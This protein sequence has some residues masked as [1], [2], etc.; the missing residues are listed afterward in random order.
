MAQKYYNVAQTAEIL[1][2]SEDAVKQMQ[3]NR[4]LHG[5]RDG[6]DW[7]FKVE[8]IDRMANEG[9]E[10]PSESDQADV[11]LSEVELGESD[12]GA[13]GTVIGMETGNKS[14]A[15]SDLRIADDDFQ[16][17]DSGLSLADEPEPAEESAI[18]EI[19][20]ADD[21]G[22]KAG[23]F[24]DLDDELDLTLEEDL[25]L[26]DDLSLAEGPAEVAEGGS[27]VDLAGSQFE[28]DDLVLGGNGGGSDISI[29]G[30]SGI[31][32]VDPADSGLSLEEPLELVSSSEES[33]ELGEDDILSL[34]DDEDTAPVA[35]AEA[36][37]DDFLLTP[38]EDASDEDDSESGSQVIALDTEGEPDEAATMIAGA[39]GGGMAAMLEEDLGDGSDMV[40][41]GSPMDGAAP[42]GGQPAGLAAGQPAT[43]A[44]AAVAETPYSVWNV[45]S[46]AMCAIFLSLTGMM[47]YDL[48]RNMWS[49]DSAYQVNSSIMEFILGLFE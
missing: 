8:D 39:G 21:G 42:L 28:D 27:D 36:E 44:A 13:S 17:A 35:E 10:T 15:D 19:P 46:L 49:W 12:P 43:P 40:D 48:M 16:L 14:S 7:K 30:D 33:L 37:E 3:A 24:E 22:S 38:L 26:D 25:T 29:G 41:L 9:V 6:I 18:E 1:G 5:Y 47:M 4:K 23:Q 45:L 2:I 34:S 11:L 32:L 31:S 20:L